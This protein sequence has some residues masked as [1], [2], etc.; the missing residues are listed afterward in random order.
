MYHVKV[1]LST[2]KRVLL[3]LTHDPRTIALI[4]VLPCV[5]LSL[6][7]WVYSDNSAV[8]NQIGPALLAIFPLIIMFLI[9]SIATLR[10]RTSGTLERVLITP[11]AKLDLLV[12]YALAFGILA[13]VQALIANFVALTFLNLDIAGPVWFLIVIGVAGALLGMALGL[14]FSVFAKNEFQA[15]QFMPA[16]I[17]PQLLVCGL[18]VPLDKMPDVLSGIAHALPMTYAVQSLQNVANETSVSG[19]SWRDLFIVLGCVAIAI[20]LGALT[21]RRSTK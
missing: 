5:L 14:F 1:T 13:I 9:T 2:A 11:I 17:F 4:F 19:Q 20:L 3:Q 10:E 21:L 18:L 16:V 7:A 15:V 12:G 8:F 6:L